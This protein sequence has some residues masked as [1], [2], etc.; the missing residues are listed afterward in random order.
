ML[1]KVGVSTFFCGVLCFFCVVSGFAEESVGPVAVEVTSGRRGTV[2]FTQEYS[3]HL[4]PMAEVRVFANASGKVVSV[5]VRVGQRVKA[6]ETV[7][8]MDSSD[9]ALAEIR[10]ASALWGAQSQ[11]T[12]TEANAQGR[13]ESEL[14]VAQERLRTAQGQVVETESLAEM[15]V[16]NQVVQ[17]EAAYESA[18]ATVARSKTSAEQG[19][20][21]AKADLDKMQLDYDR[22][23]A[24]HEKQHISD[25]DFEATEQR[26]K[27]A[28]TRYEEAVVTDAQFA[29]GVTH[30]SVE[31]ARAELEVAR[32]LVESRSWEREIASAA[33]KVVQAEGALRA[34]QHLV[35]AKSWEQEIE[36]A[37]G[38][39][40]QAEEQHRLAKEQL[41]GATLKAAIAG[42]VASRELGAGDYAQSG[43]VPGAKPI[44]TLI[45]TDVLRAVWRMPVAAARGVSSGDLVLVSTESG[46]QN[47]VGTID[48][49]SPTIDREGKTV[50][51]EATVPNVLGETGAV[52]KPGMGVEVSLKTGERKNVQLFPLRAVVN[53]QGGSGTVFVVEG[54]VARVKA[55]EVGAVYGGEIEVRSELAKGVRVVVGEQHRLSDGAPV[56][57]D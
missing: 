48:L 29:E 15:R 31:K 47:I 45:G 17:A 43:S 25:S 37:R 23:K 9:A 41:A 40:R 26:L 34:A 14:A 51:V 16:R 44:V 1:L 55:V 35:D 56:S 28:K 18:V 2:V 46:L 50:R 6:G 32:K 52:L 49:M 22:S 21:R 33:S 4:E 5:D 11:L 27:V 20:A 53:I 19:L 57:V 54:G 38:A 13:V 36:I 12:L 24:L 30:L 39:V 42:V 7:A 8:E 3:G 10:A